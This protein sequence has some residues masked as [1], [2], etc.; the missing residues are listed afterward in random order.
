MKKKL[1]SILSI[2]LLMTSL[3]ACGNSQTDTEPV[4]ADTEEKVETQATVVEVDDGFL[5]I[6]GGT[7]EMGSPESENWRSPDET[8]HSV[9]VNDFYIS[10][11]EVTQQEYEELM[12][13]NPSNF[14]G[15]HL[16]VENI[17]WYDAVNYCNARSEQEGMTPVYQVADGIVSWDMSAD[18]YRL[19]TEAEWEYACRAGTTTP[20][21][22][23]TSISADEANYYGHYPYEIEENYFSQGNLETEP[24]IYRET[25]VDGI[26]AFSGLNV[27]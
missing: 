24:G 16:P 19:P 2:V 26:Y 10:P 7:F 18:G 6:T 5:L 15:G 23:E 13:S 14:N 4:S 11:Y 8:Q 9:E 3:A 12:G 1:G 17:S 22:T 21:N 20:F 25:T 27:G